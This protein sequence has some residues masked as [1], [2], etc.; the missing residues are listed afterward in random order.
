LSRMFFDQL[1]ADTPLN[2]YPS[3]LGFDDFV[4]R[5]KEHMSRK[6]TTYPPHNVIK[7]GSSYIIE[8]ALAG[9]RREQIDISLTERLLTVAAVAGENQTEGL[10]YIHKGIAQRSFSKQFLLNDNIDVL[11]AQMADGLLRVHLAERKKPTI[12]IAVGSGQTGRQVYAVNTEL[13]NEDKI[14]DYVDNLMS[15][16]KAPHDDEATAQRIDEKLAGSLDEYAALEDDPIAK[17]EDLVRMTPDRPASYIPDEILQSDELVIAA[18]N[19][20]AQEKKGKE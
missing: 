19:A 16:Y 17:S 12:K 8:F 5:A 3:M 7:T 6:D 20:I 2:K 10:E 15:K 14:N 13:L 11:D 18:A 4:L 9:F 1:T